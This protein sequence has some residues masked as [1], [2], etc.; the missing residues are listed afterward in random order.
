MAKVK[1]VD[2]ATGKNERMSYYSYFLG[3]NA[4]YTMV[5]NFLTTYLLFQGLDPAKSGLVMLAVK[6]WDAVNDTIFGVIF[7]S[8]RFKSGKKY[9]PWLKVSTFFIPLSTVLIYMIPRSSGETVKLIWFA[10]AYILWDTAYTLCDVPIYGIVTAMTQRIDERTSLLSFKSIWAGL[11][12]GVALILGT[13]LVGEKVGLNFGVAAAAV[14]LISFFTM[15]PVN[16]NVKERF[17]SGNDE[18]FTVKRMF[19]YLFGNKY[20]L[21]YY[22]GFFVQGS[23]AVGPP[24]ALFVSY[25]MFNNSQFS[26]IIMALAVLPMLLAALFVP[27][28]LKHIDK[29]KLYLICTALNIVLSLVIWFVGYKSMLAF[30]LLSVLRSVPAAIVGVT[31][32]MFTPDCAE[33][34]LFKSGIDAKGITF[35]IQTFMAKITGALSGSLGLILLKLFEWKAVEAESFEELQK[36][37]VSQS[38]RAMGGL[39]FIYNIVPVIGLVAAF[40]IWQFYKLSDKD[41]QIMAD[42]NTGSIGRDEALSLLN[43]KL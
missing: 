19:K 30:A 21:I 3:Q 20:L 15:L 43:K 16:F 34:G 35:A 33:Y 39:W 22:F 23:L 36:L 13:V 17:K 18:E 40:I 26:L 38:P 11:G 1:N 27:R 4:I 12:S 9:L 32:F 5:T 8:V 7:D 2:W 14:A 37:A 25:Y 42:A 31:M 29:M 10:V 6:V 28:L 41:V 24:L